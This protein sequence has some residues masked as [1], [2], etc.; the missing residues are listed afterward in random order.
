[1]SLLCP[2]SGNRLPTGCQPV[3]RG[4][5]FAKSLVNI[6]C[7]VAM[8][9]MVVILVIATV[10]VAIV[11]VEVGVVAMREAW[12]FLSLLARVKAETAPT[13]LRRS[14]EFCFLR[15]WVGFVAVAAQTAFAAT[16][17]G[18]L[19]SK[20]QAWNDLEPALGEVLCDR[21]EAAEGPSR[22]L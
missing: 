2:P 9:V 17:V 22:L 10:V 11:E 14:T 16:L 4:R 8:I 21:L 13:A 20:T 19:S 6:N 7:I 5:E 15:R 18:E 1:M 3:G 12:T